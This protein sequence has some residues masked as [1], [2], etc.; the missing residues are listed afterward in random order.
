[1][2]RGTSG[3]TVRQPS[4]R[5]VREPF[6][7]ERTSGLASY[8]PPERWDDWE[9]RGPDGRTRRYFL[10]PTVCFNCEAACGLLAYVDKET[11]DIRKLE[12]HPFHPGSRGR[13]CAKGPATINQV[14]DPERILYPLRRVGPR[15]SG[16]W[17][18]VSWDVV[19]DDIA[20]RMRQAFLEGR[21]NEVMYHV[22]RPGEDG[23]MERVLWSWG[24]DGHNS[25][26]N[27]CSSGGRFGYAVWMGADRPSPDHA[28][29]R[30]IFLVSAHLESGHYFN[31]H[32]QR[33]MEAKQRGAKLAVMDPRLSNTAAMADYWLPAAPG[34]EAF[35]LLAIANVLIQE[36]WFDR[37]FVRRWTNWDEY[38]RV[39]HPGCPVT[40]EEFVAR[41]K[42]IY[43]RY[44]PEA[45]EQLSG[46][47]AAT[48]VELARELARAAPAVSTHNWRAAAAAH[49]GGWTVPRALF[50]LNVLTGSVGTPGGTQ[51]NIWD[52]FV[53]RPFKEPPRQKVWNELTWP[54]EYPLAHHEMSFLLP[55][56][57]KEGRGKLA[58]YFTRVYNPV[59]TN[60]DGFTWIEVLQDESLI[61]LHACLT[62]T[63]SE[64]AWYADY[65]LPMGHGPER[66]DTF[67]YET[68]A[69]RWIGFRQPVLRVARE[70]LGQSVQYTYEANP[71]EVWEENE[72]W[73]ELSW[74]VDPDGSLGIR[75]YYE[76]PYRPGQ[77]ITVDEYYQWIFENSIPGLPEA[78][79]A[80]GLTPLQYMRRYG[81]FEI[82]LQRYRQYEDPVP[83]EELAQS[84]IDPENGRIWT[85][86]PAPHSPNMVPVPAEPP[87]PH[88]R[89]A[90]V[91][92]DG[93]PKRG[94]PTPSGK[95]E[96]FS[97]TLYEWGW[98]EY[99]IP[100]TIESHVAP[101]QIDRSK[102]EMVLLPNFRVPT[103]IHT[104]SGNAKWLNELT[105]SNP[106]W[107]HPS[108]AE[109]IGVR[110]G[111]L[112]RVET[113]IGYFVDRVWVT[114][115]IRPGV[116]ACSHHLGRWRLAEGTGGERWTTALVNIE[117][118]P[119]G[120][121][122]LRQQH[123]VRPF[124]SED[125]DSQLVF[126]SDAG[127]HQ[128]LTFPV[129][130]DPISGQHCWHQKV[131]IVKAGPD[132]RYGD[133][134]VDTRKSMEVYRRWLAMTRP[135][136]GPGGLRRPLWM[137]RPYKPDPSAYRIDSPTG[138]G[139]A[140]RR[141]S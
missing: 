40:F 3:T 130:P 5:A 111:D 20:G 72:F 78:A 105:H 18:R 59:W 114:E 100:C 21:H 110:T 43:A 128:N 124:A 75:Q 37:E 104:R 55:H 32:A 139:D 135:A 1:M 36:G 141:S 71:G 14:K 97:R 31:P 103:L 101:S 77:K 121:Y 137:L 62:P 85:T 107:L 90:G 95:L 99:A 92:V 12:G 91:M 129:Q 117:R 131:R 65:V 79:A 48:I 98:P 109:R 2:L 19:L 39:V 45:A 24:V 28:N 25:H 54:K 138:R 84:W 63:W 51:P 82:E 89:W 123:G 76:S 83:P 57:L 53:P 86:A 15:G 61:E 26:T 68:H 73:M 11:L 8:P 102:G 118:L 122:R 58:V 6:V 132:D 127:V 70:K 23:F 67:S 94:F 119:D 93:E 60:P 27:V 136:P 9:E 4:T 64:T 22:G 66:H 69:A 13:N 50:F 80:E 7:P 140:S 120:R 106:L 116:A 88:G 30:F 38:L 74:R 49:L 16:K 34:T 41:L 81:A 96:F 46:I 29:A 10:I 133:V 35:V 17:E 112:V 108:D 125:P 42:E 113:E 115:A 134:V 56:F 52:K 87:G 126:W 47:P 33:I 44:T